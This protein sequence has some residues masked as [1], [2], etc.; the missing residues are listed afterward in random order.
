MSGVNDALVDYGSDLLKGITVSRLTLPNDANVYG[1]VHGG[2][3]LK[4]IEEAGI[5]LSTRFCNHANK[6][7]G[8]IITTMSRIESVSFLRPMKI[9]EVAELTAE[10]IYTS[11]K[12]ILIEV[13][14]MA[15]DIFAARKNITNKACLWYVAMN[16]LEDIVEVPQITYKSEDE[17]SRA[18]Q[19]YG[20]WYQESK[21]EVLNSIKPIYFRSSD[22]SI[23]KV[24]QSETFL[25][26][27]VGP[28]DVAFGEI[29]RGGVVLKLMDECG[30]IVA[31]K[32]CR[33]N[34]V[35]ACLDATNFYAQIRK[36]NVLT[37]HG[38]ATF[39][40]K[41]SMEIEIVVFVE[42]LFEK[43]S[44]FVKAIDSF[45]TYVSIGRDGNV[46]DIPPLTL[47]NAEEEERYDAG[48]KRYTK[49]KEARMNKPNQ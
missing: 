15:E 9:G 40:S 23:H 26:V 48:M 44:K 35:T 32:H 45:F 25:S 33:T 27:M 41:R 13:T 36:G 22:D 28:D 19:L 6:A 47:G 46:L 16:E 20:S 18:K 31:A 12:A 17:E 7:K 2:V 34:V 49:R 30:G 38:R 24:S 21:Y 11:S 1:N 4:M 8:K 10:I 39:T 43:E 29:C 42:S 37:V 14:V 5:I 3:T